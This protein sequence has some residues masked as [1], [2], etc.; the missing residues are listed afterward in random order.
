MDTSIA[1]PTADIDTLR[2]ATFDT[3]VALART[4][5][6]RMPVNVRSSIH[7]TVG[8]TVDL[9]FDRDDQVHLWAELLNIGPV[10]AH[11]LDD[12]AGAGWL[13]ACGY[14]WGKPVWLGWLMVTVRCYSFHRVPV[15]AVVAQPAET[16]AQPEAA[17]TVDDRPAT[18]ICRYCGKELEQLQ[19]GWCDL[20]G[21]FTC[22]KDVLH[23]AISERRPAV[24]PKGPI[25]RGP[26]RE[27]APIESGPMDRLAEIGGDK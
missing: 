19:A 2:Q 5:G 26:Y 22:K 10:T 17:S 21:W 20:D 23:E 25:S 24:P 9:N 11:R 8:P 3:L 1:E 7:E 14:Q 15:A 12:P 6:L 4:H 13:E 18:G 16:N 27:H